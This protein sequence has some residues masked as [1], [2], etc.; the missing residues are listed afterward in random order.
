MKTKKQNRPE[1]LEAEIQKAMHEII[2]ERL[3]NPEICGLI[4]VSRV[5]CSRDLT[6]ARVYISIYDKDSEKRQ[7]S[8]NKINESKGKIRH[9]LGGMVQT[10]VVPEID[11]I[12][13]NSMEYSKKIN[14]LIKGL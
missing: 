1:R 5:E 13:D 2:T 11:F 10:R 12:F 7:N 4:S 14:K 3:K 6:H 8:F 9:H